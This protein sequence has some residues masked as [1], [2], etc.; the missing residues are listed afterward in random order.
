MTKSNNLIGNT[1]G[2]SIHLNNDKDFLSD[3][4]RKMGFMA[5]YETIERAEVPGAGNMNFVL[6]IVPSDSPSFIVKQARPWVEKF[7]DIPAP[8]ERMETEMRYYDA[9]NSNPSLAIYSPVIIGFDENN[10]ILVLE[11]LG[12][13]QDYTYIYKKGE[14]MDG[15]E[16]EQCVG[17]INE[18]QA[19]AFHKHYPLN[20]TL[21]KL[22][23]QHI[24]FLPFMA[25][26]GFNL[27]NIQTGLQEISTKC[28]TDH[29]LISRVRALGDEY[30]SSG[31]T[32]LQGDFYPGSLLR[33]EGEFR[34]IDPEFSFYGP[35]E[36]DIS[37]FIA[38]LIMAETDERLV[39]KAFDN[40]TQKPAFN[41]ERFSGFV[42]TEIL[43]RLVGLAQLPLELDLN[44]KSN[45]ID[46]S[47]D[48]VKSG[49]VDILGG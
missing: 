16:M 34:V 14:K 21:R 19:I 40:Y 42:G 29:D 35:A 44:Q 11:D 13:S 32:L 7:P 23:H 18:L 5:S 49:K 39:K 45:L 10:F 12:E 27:D 8:V 6:R 37:V 46:R 9:V 3:Y 36:W 25:N 31:D 38:H 33:V 20:L 2:Q 26:N 17:Y 28:T 30:L 4:L 47:I 22:N 15:D 41:M 48:W 1:T 43:R 24:F